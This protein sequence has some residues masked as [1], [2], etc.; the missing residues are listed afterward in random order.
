MCAI[1]DHSLLIE[2]WIWYMLEYVSSCVRY[3]S[4]VSEV[5]TCVCEVWTSVYVRYEHVSVGSDPSKY[6]VWSW[7]VWYNP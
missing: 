4:S 5:W 3:D 6:E 2:V 7:G 1:S